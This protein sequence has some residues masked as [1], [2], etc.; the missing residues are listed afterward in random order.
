MSS[1]FADTT[2]TNQDRWETGFEMTKK[3]N[4]GPSGF[5]MTFK[6]GF[7]ISV[8]W[9]SCH[10]ASARF[11]D[12]ETAPISGVAKFSSTAEIA[13][14]NPDMSWMMLHEY[15]RNT[16]EWDSATDDVGWIGPDHIAEIIGVLQSAEEDITPWGET[17]VLVREIIARFE[18]GDG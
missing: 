1:R 15:S 6:N 13:V 17:A 10:Y 8:Q 4:D 14:F 12:G 9:S 5:R 18:K 7:T 11:Q 16:P 2:D 3:G